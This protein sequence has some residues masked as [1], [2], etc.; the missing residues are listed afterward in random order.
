MSGMCFD[1]T[2]KNTCVWKRFDFDVQNMATILILI[3]NT[4]EE[5][6]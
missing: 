3:V 1:V 5:P 6:I 2:P 4:I